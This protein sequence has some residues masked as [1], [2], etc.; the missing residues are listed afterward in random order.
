MSQS[1]AS[2]EDS[3]P[4]TL[5]SYATAVLD[6]YELILAGKSLSG[7]E[8][9]CAYLNTG[10]TRFAN[11][12]AVSGLDF[13]DDGRG[14]A[15]ADWD[16]DGDVD[17]WISNRTAPRLRFLRNDTETPNQFL[18]VRL[19]GNG[20]TCNRD[21]IGT[22]IWTR[23]LNKNVQMRDINSGSTHGGGDERAAYFG[24]GSNPATKVNVRIRWP[25]G[26]VQWLHNQDVDQHIHVVQP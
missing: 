17:L 23:E 14:M 24:F 22:R 25:N 18:A 6:L 9:H 10:D 20:T 3:T 16:F 15:A 26:T 7:R 11:I 21:A 8:R 13:P 19:Q 4:E 1:P 12:S 5:K 2:L